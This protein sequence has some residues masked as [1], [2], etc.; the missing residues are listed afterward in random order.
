MITKHPH[1]RPLDSK[2]ESADVDFK[3]LCVGTAKVKGLANGVA[4]EKGTEP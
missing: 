3:D 2:T 4:T 1:R